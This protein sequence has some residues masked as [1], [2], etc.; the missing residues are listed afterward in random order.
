MRRY[1][2]IALFL[3]A[4]VVL[5]S[6][7]VAQPDRF[8]GEDACLIA[9]PSDWEVPEAIRENMRVGIK[10]YRAQNWEAARAAFRQV[11]C[12]K[13]NVG[14][15]ASLAAV[16]M[17]LGAFADAARHWEYVIQKAT[18]EQPAKRAEAEAG[19]A[20]CRERLGRARVAFGDPS[21]GISVDG[22]TVSARPGDDSWVN[23]GEHT[24]EL[25]LQDGRSDQQ[26]VTIAA[27]ELRTIQMIIPA[28]PNLAASVASGLD[29]PSPSPDRGTTR[30]EP[31]EGHSSA[32]TP[33]VITGAALTAVAVGAG[34]VFVLQANSAASDVERFRAQ[35]EREG[36]PVLVQMNGECGPLAAQQ[37]AV[38]DDLRAAADDEAAAKSRAAGAFIAAGV[39]GV[40]TVAT[41]FLWP[42]RES[43]P[44]RSAVSVAPFMLDGANGVQVRMGF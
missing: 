14:S 43:S 2:G 4:G 30:D 13:P 16:E 7:A 28:K 41:Y 5:P 12:L 3:L 17:K 38:C 35:T 37:P 8:F 19:L 40:A 34:I 23:P 1:Y 18:P 29:A 31:K 24:F 11:W 27:G 42:T 44:P 9:P 6:P 26:K 20:E 33:L 39:L 21:A 32:R 36:D 15:A 10:E 25:R 22:R